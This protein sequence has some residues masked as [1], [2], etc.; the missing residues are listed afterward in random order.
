[1]SNREEALRRMLDPRFNA[2]EGEKAN[3]R[4]ALEKIAARNAKEPP[5]VVVHRSPPPQA[6]APPPPPRR[7]RRAAPCPVTGSVRVDRPFPPK[8]PKKPKKETR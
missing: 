5:T 1:V 3:A 2:T 4:R 7:T 6:A 8:K